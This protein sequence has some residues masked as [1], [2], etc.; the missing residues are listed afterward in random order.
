MMK[1]VVVC[2]FATLLSSCAWYGSVDRGD[3]L[4]IPCAYALADPNSG[5]VKEAIE[6]N[7]E[8]WFIN[9]PECDAKFDELD[10]GIL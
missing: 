8:N 10:R 1:L 5:T 2:L 4:L 9:Q 3:Y 6:A 7:E